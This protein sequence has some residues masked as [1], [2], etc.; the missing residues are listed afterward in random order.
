MYNIFREIGQKYHKRLAVAFCCFLIPSGTI[1]A[2]S[3][4]EVSV[5]GYYQQHNRVV[6]DNLYG[7]DLKGTYI[8][9]P[10]WRISI[11]TGAG[12]IDWKRK[13][14]NDY[15][16]EMGMKS[17]QVFVPLKAQMKYNLLK[18]GISPYAG[19]EAGYC[20]S[21]GK[22]VCSPG[23]TYKPFIGVDIPFSGSTSPFINRTTCFIQYGY[24]FQSF[25]RNI[26][27]R[28]S[29]QSYYPPAM[30]GPH[31]GGPSTFSNKVSGEMNDF[32][33][34]LTYSL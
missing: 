6:L 31:Y 28:G 15:E 19:M 33:I 14:T 34:G 16:R 20:V 7:L 18:K 12:I 5:S 29:G 32:V 30:G 1:N 10:H 9:T 25:N 4:F 26:Y 17:N 24:N 21:F 22:G 8:L 11:V 23:A 2:Q 13:P 27:D 3:H